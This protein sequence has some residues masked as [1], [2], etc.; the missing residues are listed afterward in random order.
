M[1]ID[2][3]SMSR[4]RHRVGE[5]GA[6]EL[7]KETIKAGLTLKAIKKSQL[8]R[9]NVDSTVQEKDIRFPTDARLYNRARE[10]L[11][12]AAVER[13][14]PLRQNYNRLGPQKLLKQSRY[15]HAKQMKR[16]RKCTRNLKRYMSI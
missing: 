8:K 10:R 9:V 14:I 5:S 1:P 12:K 16:A 7:L 13:E 4:W 11:V 6:E 3:S 2:P 15:A